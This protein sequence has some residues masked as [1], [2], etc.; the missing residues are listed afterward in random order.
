MAQSHCQCHDVATNGERTRRDNLGIS[1]MLA[2]TW[3]PVRN[4]SQNSL[5]EAFAAKVVPTM[6]Q[7]SAARLRITGESMLI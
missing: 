2:P 3:I 7:N 1:W 4:S 5:Q 6:S